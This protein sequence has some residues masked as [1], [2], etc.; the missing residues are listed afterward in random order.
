MHAGLSQNLTHLELYW[1]SKHVGCNNYMS[2]L[3]QNKPWQQCWCIQIHKSTELCWM[4]NTCTSARNIQQTTSHK[5]AAIPLI[6]CLPLPLCHPQRCSKYTHS[7]CHYPCTS[8]KGASI[9]LTLHLPLPLC[10]PQRCS[11]ST[12]SLSAITP[13]PV[14]MVQQFHS[15]SACHYSCTSHND[16]AIPL[17]LFAITPVPTMKVQ[18]C[19]SLFITN[20]TFHPTF[21]NSVP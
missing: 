10:H 20:L 16:A 18:Q 13:A 15:L 9:P 14:T 8:H 4:H 2:L 21:S 19:C 17:T 5:G 11:N 12:H 3:L 7:V 1:S 6:L